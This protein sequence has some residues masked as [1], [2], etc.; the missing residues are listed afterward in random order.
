MGI[1]GDINGVNGVNGERMEDL[2]AVEEEC[3]YIMRVLQNFSARMEKD[4]APPEVKTLLVD[5]FRRSGGVYFR[6]DVEGKS[7]QWGR[8]YGG[9]WW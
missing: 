5:F 7:W 2:Q 4:E 6:C 9:K 1:E 3:N 8:N